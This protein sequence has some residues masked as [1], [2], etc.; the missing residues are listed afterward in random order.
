MT[1]MAATDHDII[2]KAIAGS[3]KDLQTRAPDEFRKLT[4][5]QLEELKT[6]A[7]N[8]AEEEVKLSKVLHASLSHGEIESILEKHLPKERVE[9]IKNGLTIPT[10]QMRLSKQPEGH[11]RV[12]ITRD[13]TELMPSFLLSTNA[14]LLKASWIQIASIVVEAVL[15]VLSAVGVKV[16]ADKYVIKKVAEEIVGTIESSSLLQQAVKQ[17]EEAFQS[18]SAWEKAKAIFYLIKDSYSAGILWQ[19]IKGLCENMSTSDWIKTAAIVSAEII[20][21]LATDGAALIAK[22]VLALNSAYEFIKKL[23]NLQELNAMKK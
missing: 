21:A 8:A 15:L 13:G 22:I 14:D 19:I 17:L 2:D 23:T 20:A 4:Q 9:L 5:D 12:D 1:E 6:A 11:V 7:R 16:S 10:Y 3:L 18:G